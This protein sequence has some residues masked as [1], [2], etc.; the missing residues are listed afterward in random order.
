[1][2]WRL[3]QWLTDG[4]FVFRYDPEQFRREDP[5]IE[6]MNLYIEMSRMF[7]KQGVYDNVITDIL[8]CGQLPVYDYCPG[9]TIATFDKYGKLIVYQL[10]GHRIFVEL[11]E[12]SFGYI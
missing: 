7:S 12:I 10:K 1:M 5:R 8:T 4:M 6:K 11:R 2:A 9:T 3:L